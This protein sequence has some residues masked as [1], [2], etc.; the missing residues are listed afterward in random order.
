MLFCFNGRF[1]YFL[2]SVLDG[3]LQM[4]V[5]S[6]LFA[7]SWLCGNSPI[8]EQPLNSCMPKAQPLQGVLQVTGSRKTVTWHGAY[9]KKGAPP[10]PLQLHSPHH[11][12]SCL[13]RAKPKDRVADHSRLWRKEANGKYSGI[14]PKLKQSQTYCPGF[15][16]KAMQNK[17]IFGKSEISLT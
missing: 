11:S 2:S 15:F 10:K 14:K 17:M 3:N 13:R 1:L 12:V 7:L 8:L 6:L 16:Q 5:T 4:T 9:E